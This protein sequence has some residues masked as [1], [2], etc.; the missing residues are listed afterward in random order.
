MPYVVAGL[1]FNKLL[2]SQLTINRL[3]PRNRFT[4]TYDD[5]VP[6]TATVNREAGLDELGG[7]L[8]GGLLWQIANRLTLVA[9]TRLVYSAAF[10]SVYKVPTVTNNEPALSPRTFQLN[11]SIGISV[12]L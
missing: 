3:Y 6:W 12:A 2:R 9:D 11:N 5:F 10:I 4:A 1:V 8:G 7:S